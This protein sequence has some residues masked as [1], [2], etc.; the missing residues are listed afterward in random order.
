MARWITQEL[1]EQASIRRVTSIDGFEM[2]PYKGRNLAGLIIPNIFPGEKAP[3]EYRIR[4]DHPDYELQMN[5]SRHETRKYMAPP[6]RPP[7]IYWPVGVTPEMLTDIM[8]P[9]IITEGEF[10]A[11][12]LWRLA[13]EGGVDKPRF[14]PVGL[15]GVDC[16][17]GA[18]GKTTNASGQRVSVRGMLPDL[19]SRMAWKTRAVIIAYDADLK[20]NDHVLKARDRLTY[21]LAE[22]GALIAKLEWNSAKGK[23]IDDYLATVGPETVLDSIKQLQFGDWQIRLLRDARGRLQVGCENVAL[24]LE[25]HPDW[26]GAIAYNEFTGALS[27]IRPAPVSFAVGAELED[28]FDTEVTRWFDRHH[29]NAMPSIITRVVDVIARQNPYHPVRDYLESLPDWDGIPRISTWLIDYCGVSV[30]D[31][32]VLRY[33]RAVGEKFLISAVARILKPGCKVDHLL[34]LEGAQGIGK[35]T[36]P[37]ILAGDE[38]FTD[39]LADL[40]HKKDAAQMLR[41]R[42]IIEFGE[43]DAFS[44]S[45]MTRINSFVTQQ[46]D[47]FR[48]PYGRR[49]VEFPRQ[50]VFFGTTNQDT[51]C[52]DETGGRRFWP[53]HC[54]EIEVE[55]LHTNR[56]QIWAEALAQYYNGVRWWLD[57]GEL[58]EQAKQQQ[59]GRYMVD[60]WHEDV[61]AHAIRIASE[62]EYDSASIPEILN[63]IGVRI[64]DQDQRMANRI[65]HC[66]RFE[67]WE[68]RQIRVAGGRRQWR[69]YPA[70]SERDFQALGVT[71]VT[72]QKG[73]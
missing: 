52:K 17:R 35:S 16:W 57:D 13:W 38:W 20:S 41:G 70:I 45:E 56:N 40:T 8:L 22:R 24:F 30:V 12:A 48:L 58:I 59:E 7:L 68:R 21:A 15:Q 47:R 66:L 55:P 11:I 28:Y 50:C 54:G 36:V 27:L 23:G 43:L 62:D 19:A 32:A 42:W 18:I 2:F 65:A 72:N 51:W 61:I 6:D 26:A 31:D 60:P 63:R 44:R 46:T 14:L 37:R 33:I 25:N 71:S 49:V 67:K 69:Y 34:I 9:V 3:R 29:L 4:L 5:G 64:Q 10:K 39:Q 1:A 53:V 73:T